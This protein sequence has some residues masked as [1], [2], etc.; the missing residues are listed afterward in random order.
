MTKN[1]LT[2]SIRIEPPRP[3]KVAMKANAYRTARQSNSQLLPMFPYDGPGDIVVTCAAIRAGGAA[4]RLGY[5]LHMNSVDEVMVSFGSNGRVRTGDV[6][7]G[8][9]THGVGGSTDV[10]FFAL[11]TVTQRQ[12]ECGEQPEAIIFSCE[13]CREE[14]FR[15]EFTGLGVD[16]A[17]SRFPGLPS[18]IGAAQGAKTFNAS[19][20]ARTCPACGHVNQTF[21][22]DKW[23]WDVYDARTEIA[24]TAWR[25]LEGVVAK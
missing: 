15:H 11:T 1:D 12:L 7:V 25:A 23:G 21:P 8:P 10:E 14:V 6:N 9:R 24:E 5:F 13:S 19:E 18:I 20:A 16:G 4:G 2:S 17:E 22:I 3:G